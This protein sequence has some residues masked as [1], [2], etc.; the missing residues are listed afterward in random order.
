MLARRRPD[1]HLRIF[2]D[3]AFVN[4]QVD[5]HAANTALWPAVARSE[6]TANC[7]PAIYPSVFGESKRRGSAAGNEQAPLQRRMARDAVEQLMGRRRLNEVIVA[8][9]QHKAP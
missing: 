6:S 9:H 3:P 4:L 8:Q 5:Q 7:M 2:L 1:S